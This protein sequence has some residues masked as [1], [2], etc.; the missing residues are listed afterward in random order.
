MNNIGAHLTIFGNLHDNNYWM[1]T[2]HRCRIYH[3]ITVKTYFPA[4]FLI[5]QLKSVVQTTHMLLC[6]SALVQKF[7]QKS[8][9]FVTLSTK[10]N[11]VNN[12]QNSSTQ[13][14]A[15]TPLLKKLFK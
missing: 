6:Q 11:C 7:Y 4:L 12:D 5:N 8:M 10:L 2:W 9:S 14:K 13:K 15:P 1:N 3:F